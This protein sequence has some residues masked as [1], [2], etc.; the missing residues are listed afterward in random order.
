[1]CGTSDTNDR[2]R[3]PLDEFEASVSLDLVCSGSSMPSDVVHILFLVTRFRHSGSFQ[4][5]PHQL[6]RRYVT[7]Y[8]FKILHEIR[9]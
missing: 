2:T 8:W 3:P 7:D 6:R 9:S 5:I 4:E 1:M